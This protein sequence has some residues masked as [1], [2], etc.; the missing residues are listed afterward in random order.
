M[1]KDA[2]EDVEEMMNQLRGDRYH[3]IWYRCFDLVWRE[4]E[5]AAQIVPSA[6]STQISIQ[7]Y[8]EFLAVFTYTVKFT[9][10]LERLKDGTMESWLNMWT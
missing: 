6:E 3:D 4:N 7:T 2:H 8:M 9:T 5:K 1:H 10:S